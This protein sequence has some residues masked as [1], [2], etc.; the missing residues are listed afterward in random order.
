MAASTLASRASGSGAMEAP[1]S[2]P[3]TPP[4]LGDADRPAAPRADDPGELH[5]GGEHRPPHPDDPQERAL[6]V[7]RALHRPDLKPSRPGQ[8]AKVDRRWVCRVDADKIARD[9]DRVS[10]QGA[11]GYE[12]AQERAHELIIDGYLRLVV[13]SYPFFAEDP[14]VIRWNSVMY[15]GA[16]GQAGWDALPTL[17]PVGRPFTVE[18]ARPA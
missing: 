8:R 11:G 14:R 18:I 5:R 1:L 2:I 10:R 4:S 17:T 7:E 15:I 9:L 3:R 12:A 13:P 16:P 6:L